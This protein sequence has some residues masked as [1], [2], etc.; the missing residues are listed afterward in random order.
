MWMVL[1]QEEAARVK[2]DVFKT[3]ED[4]FAFARSEQNRIDKELEEGTADPV[5]H[6]IVVS[7]VKLWRHKL[8]QWEDE[9]V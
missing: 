9:T 2:T 1:V 8:E 3:E 7:E 6:L 5:L 4:A